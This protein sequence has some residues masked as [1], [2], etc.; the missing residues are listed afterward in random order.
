MEARRRALGR[1]LGALIQPAQ[2][3]AEQPNADTAAIEAVRPNP[4][5]PRTSFSEQALEE[6]AASIR[7]KGLLQPLLV[8]RSGDHFE[9]IAGE[10]R[11]RAAQMAGLE[12]V[13]IRIR[14]GGD[15]DSLELALIEN[16]QRENLNPIEE[17]KAFQR[18]ADEFALTQE[19]IAVRVGK[20][21]STIANSLRL[22]SL[23]IGIQEKIES[24]VI[25]AGHARALL[26]LASADKQ[27][28]MA[29]SISESQL[30]VRDTERA[31]RAQ[32][33][34]PADPNRQAVEEELTRSFGMRVRIKQT[35]NG[36]G[37]LE[38][39]YHSMEALNRLLERLR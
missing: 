25:S 6:L 30:S 34:P 39:H 21:R 3:T 36:S 37:R 38:F 1:G 33:S 8:R 5:Q 13:P 29:R 24:G 16:L 28:D 17:A 31:V 19:E 9:L 18:L 23:P 4:Y 20:R 15:E 12:H 7:E 32:G 2:P 27:A 26:G 10:R 22:L 14:D 11:L 35:R